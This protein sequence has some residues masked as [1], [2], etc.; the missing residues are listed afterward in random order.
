[1]AQV[2]KILQEHS[3]EA[4]KTKVLLLIP[5]EDSRAL[6]VCVKARVQPTVLGLLWYRMYLGW[7]LRNSYFLQALI[8][9]GVFTVK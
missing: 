6:L 7:C 8:T 1:M 5:T 9:N 4:L 2:I 3:Y